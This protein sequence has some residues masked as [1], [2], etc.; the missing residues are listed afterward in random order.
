[1]LKESVIRDIATDEVS[2]MSTPYPMVQSMAKEILKL[3]KLANGLASSLEDVYDSTAVLNHLGLE[4]NQ[5]LC[6]SLTDYRAKYP[7]E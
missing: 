3:R 4:E 1:M 2:A 5:R 6:D 7:K